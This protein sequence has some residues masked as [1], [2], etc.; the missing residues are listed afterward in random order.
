MEKF[1]YILL[2]A[3][4][5]MIVPLIIATN[6][7]QFGDGC[8]DDANVYAVNGNNI[9]FVPNDPNTLLL[10]WDDSNDIGCYWLSI[11]LVG[12]N[13]IDEAANSL[14][15]KYWDGGCEPIMTDLHVKIGDEEHTATFEDFFRWMGFKD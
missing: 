13:N 5:L 2:L 9:F 10:E 15:T 3:G 4:I 7:Y 8:I 14:R 12:V 1:G 11:S 6:K